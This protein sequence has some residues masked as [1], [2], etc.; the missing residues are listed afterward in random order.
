MFAFVIV[1]RPLGGD[2]SAFSLYVAMS[3]TSAEALARVRERFGLEG[4]CEV[5][6]KPLASKT[7]DAL[8]L[9]PGDVRAL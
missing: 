8:G 2:T 3:E 6:G 9:Q 4:S 7:A 1:H 5:N